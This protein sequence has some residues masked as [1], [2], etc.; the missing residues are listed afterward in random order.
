[1]FAIDRPVWSAIALE[2][3]ILTGEE[4]N[5]SHAHIHQVRQ[6]MGLDNWSEDGPT[7][8]PHM[9]Q[10]MPVRKEDH[11]QQHNQTPY[12]YPSHDSTTNSTTTT[13]STST[14]VALAGGVPLGDPGDGGSTGLAMNSTGRY[15][16]AWMPP[17]TPPYISSPQL[18]MFEED[19]TSDHS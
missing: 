19:D 3:V 9:G 16:W 17:S 18:T 8:V 11:Q 6:S 2:G 1:V 15:S 10:D 5:G 12:S 13:T 4:M 14:S 7:G